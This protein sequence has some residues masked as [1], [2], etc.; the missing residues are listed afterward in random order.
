[1]YYIYFKKKRKKNDW[2][3]ILFIPRGWLS[4][5]RGAVLLKPANRLSIMTMNNVKDGR[6]KEVVVDF[7]HH[8]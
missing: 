1:M 4:S 3:Y 2:R 8:A 6:K 5:R 7:N